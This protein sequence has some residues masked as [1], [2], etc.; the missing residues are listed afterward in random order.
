M[1]EFCQRRC[2][3]CGELRNVN[4]FHY[5][6]DTGHKSY[7]CNLCS[8]QKVN[9]PWDWSCAIK[10][11]TRMH[12]GKALGKKG[13]YYDT[14]DEDMLKSLMKAQNNKCALTQ[15]TFVLPTHEDLQAFSSNQTAKNITL[16]IWKESLI[17]EKQ[18]CVPAL[19]RV[20]SEGQWIPGNVIFICDY[21]Q[22]FVETIGNILTLQECC[23]TIAS[24]NLYVPQKDLLDRVRQDVVEQNFRDKL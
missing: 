23:K 3:K 14:L 2:P 5:N 8:L 18:R 6:P 20:S 4:Q 11:A 1:P 21:L 22:E 10:K 13:I 16:T 7:R 19:V 12:V 9:L 15:A 17:P 24:N